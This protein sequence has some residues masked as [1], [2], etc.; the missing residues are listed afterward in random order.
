MLIKA[1]VVF[2]VVSEPNPL[3]PLRDLQYEKCSSNQQPTSASHDVSC[4]KLRCN[5]PET[6][7]T[8]Q[9]IID[10]TDITSKHNNITCVLTLILGIDIIMYCIGL[11]VFLN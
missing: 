1:R 9:S 11:P 4:D 5:Q 10:Y 7:S 6:L 2:H 3:R 8:M